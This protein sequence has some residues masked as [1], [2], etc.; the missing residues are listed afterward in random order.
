VSD[1]LIA[2][3]KQ[4]NELIG[5]ASGSAAPAA[6][7]SSNLE[8]FDE[9]LKRASIAGGSEESSRNEA[10][11]S[12]DSESSNVQLLPLRWQGLSLSSIEVSNSQIQGKGIALDAE[13][14]L[15]PAIDVQSQS[16]IL[17]LAVSSELRP[18]SIQD[19]LDSYY[20]GDLSYYRNGSLNLMNY[21][22]AVESLNRFA[23]DSLVPSEI[24]KSAVQL[25]GKSEGQNPSQLDSA[26]RQAIE[27]SLS[28]ARVQN[29]EQKPGM[30]VGTERNLSQ[31]LSG[32]TARTVSANDLATH[33]RVLKNADGGEA[34]L[35]LHPIE[36]GRMVIRVITEGDEARL[37][38]TVENS[39]ARQAV[40]T[41]LPRLRDML[42]ESGFKLLDSDV[43]EHDSTDKQ[44]QSSDPPHDSISSEEISTDTP[45]LRTHLLS[46][47]LLDTFV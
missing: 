23:G 34:R 35:Q 43:H 1:T 16:A 25:I 29:S 44:D 26:I 31:Q 5:V 14:C 11:L 28:P 15:S 33:L 10:V 20:Q 37:S 21:G 7:Q 38:F 30:E 39:Q 18:V 6:S 24:D 32:K 22:I 47:H 3:V 41:S 12:Q 19:S 2:S 13:I 40:E 42:E 4:N 36:L 17:P 27:T 45:V 9:S 8:S 46:G